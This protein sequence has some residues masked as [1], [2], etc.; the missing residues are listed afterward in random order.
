VEACPRGA[1]Y[2]VEGKANVDAGL[3]RECELCVNVCPV[4]AVAV[5]SQPVPAPTE[6]VSSPVE[7]ARAA[8]PRP[9]P[10][11]IRIETEPRALTF[12]SRVLPAMGA[13]LVWAGREL[14]PYVAEHLLDSL[15]RRAAGK[16]LSTRDGKQRSLAARGGGGGRRHRRRRRGGE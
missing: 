9:E 5:A 12:K 8:V 15:D 3:C 10:E 1:L 6:S 14:V 11:V 13:A 2:L 16:Q 4:Q 7:P